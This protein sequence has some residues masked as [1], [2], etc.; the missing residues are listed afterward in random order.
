MSLTMQVGSRKRR[1]F[2]GLVALVALV[3]TGC[4]AGGVT[5]SVP[6]AEIQKKLDEKFPLSPMS[7]AG[8]PPFS[9]QLAQPKVG[10][11][12]TATR[13]TINLDV[14]VTLPSAADAP[15]PPALPELPLGPPPRLPPRPPT[16]IHGTM[17]ISGKPEWDVAQRA[18]FIRE[19]RVDWLALDGLPEPLNQPLRALA[20]SKIE[21]K[22]R[23][24][25]IPAPS[26]PVGDVAKAV[27]KRITVQ[28][29]GVSVELGL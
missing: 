9:L 24:A 28:P 15:A 12:D 19:P 10:V 16:S 3:A 26:D 7:E 27:V 2:L 22:L 23:D 18:L 20:Q 13:I 25:P 11:D 1:A 4:G 6:L 14:E 8:G 17:T 29:S 21:E 5:L